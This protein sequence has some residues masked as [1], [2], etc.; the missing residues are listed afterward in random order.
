MSVGISS[1]SQEILSLVASYLPRWENQDRA[2]SSERDPALLPPYATIS[3]SWQHVIECQTFR[4]ITVKS[5]EIDRFSHIVA[6][7]RRNLLR[8]LELNVILPTY[9]DQACAKF[10]TE[11]DKQSNNQVFTKAIKDLLTLLQS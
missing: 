4:E 6:K 9:T 7:H 2:D 3:R 10:E 1:L 11:K 8:R 5:T